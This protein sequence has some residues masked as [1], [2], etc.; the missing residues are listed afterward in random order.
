MIEI[1]TPADVRRIT[2]QELRV[3]ERITEQELA[4]LGRIP[5]NPT[6]F[7]YVRGVLKGDTTIT[8][9]YYDLLT[10]A[11]NRNQ[12]TQ[13]SAEIIDLTE[14]EAIFEAAQAVRESNPRINSLLEAHEDFGRTKSA[15]VEGMR[16]TLGL[17]YFKEGEAERVEYEPD[18]IPLLARESQLVPMAL[19]TRIHTDSETGEIVLDQP[20]EET[21]R[22]IV[23]VDTSENTDSSHIALSK[24]TPP[25]FSGEYQPND[26]RFQRA[27]TAAE[28]PALRTFSEVTVERVLPGIERILPELI[29]SQGWR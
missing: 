23:V 28:V 18:L 16:E 7:N 14:P 3:N 11:N 8:P 21:T 13:N 19:Y 20:N 4:T 29:N 6:V 17:A 5:M 26:R 2:G 24:G 1:Y 9:Q 25:E 27:I 15:I 10:W 12:L 22:L